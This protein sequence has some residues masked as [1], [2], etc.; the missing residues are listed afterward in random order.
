MFKDNTLFEPIRVWIYNTCLMNGVSVSNVYFNNCFVIMGNFG[1]TKTGT[2]KANDMMNAMGR[3]RKSNVWNAYFYNNPMN[4][5]NTIDLNDNTIQV[6]IDNENVASLNTKLINNTLDYDASTIEKHKRISKIIE[7]ESNK[8]KYYSKIITHSSYREIVYYRYV[9]T[10]TPVKRWTQDNVIQE[11][12]FET[13]D[14]PMKIEGK[15]WKEPNTYDYTEYEELINKGIIINN[16][17]ATMM[18]RLKLNSV[19]E[20]NA[21][22]IFKK[23]LFIQ[24]AKL[25]GN[26]IDDKTAEITENCKEIT[27]SINYDLIRTQGDILIIPPI[28]ETTER[29]FID[30][31]IDI[32]YGEG[33][34]EPRLLIHSS[35][36]YKRLFKNY[37]NL[38][39]DTTANNLR[40]QYI[41][42]VIRILSGDEGE[43]PEYLPD[44]ITTD[45]INNRYNSH[46]KVVI[47]EYLKYMMKKT[48][49]KISMMGV[50][51]L[52]IFP[53][54]FKYESNKDG[55]YST[56][57]RLWKYKYT[58][59]PTIEPYT[60]KV[61]YNNIDYDVNMGVDG[62]M[63]SFEWGNTDMQNDVHFSV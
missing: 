27:K 63:S 6:L 8:N 17:I 47:D 32:Y 23:D 59:T 2:I 37:V 39:T 57:K 62:L 3:A 52:I 31:D 26:I 4:N 19:Y 40:P 12:Y 10:G 50:I 36:D 42:Q 43:T 61:K 25:K 21:N 34:S 48:D 13:Y 5:L 28:K 24:L 53:Y 16:K 56:G 44:L 9:P 46:T 1:D 33:I 60:S 54:G 30:K 49:G 15:E 29:Y 11:E 51:N 18:N 14:I 20:T 58:L 41:K 7:Y 45:D 22:L 38:A 35:S 55:R